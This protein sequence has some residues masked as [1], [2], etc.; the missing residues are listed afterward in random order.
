MKKEIK[1]KKENLTDVIL[2]GKVDVE[3][4]NNE[5]RHLIEGTTD[6]KLAT[7]LADSNSTEDQKMSM[8]SLYLFERGRESSSFIADLMLYK[9]QNTKETRKFKSEIRFDFTLFLNT[10]CTFLIDGGQSILDIYRV[11]ISAAELEKEAY[12]FMAGKRGKGS[13]TSLSDFIVYKFP[14]CKK[15]ISKAIHLDSALR[16]I[17]QA[18][19]LKKDIDNMVEERERENGKGIY[20]DKLGKPTGKL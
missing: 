16:S 5:I 2:G 1:R 20:L 6:K 14:E 12:D 19:H 9:G 4:S 11:R 7:I 13:A 8:V 17:S 18:H 15:D 3:S 10:F